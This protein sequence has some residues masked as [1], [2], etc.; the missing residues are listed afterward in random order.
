M[1]VEERHPGLSAGAYPSKLRNGSFQFAYFIPAKRPMK[2]LLGWQ[3]SPNPMPSGFP[4]QRRGAGI[5]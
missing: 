1:A 3:A 5:R 2:L 4:L